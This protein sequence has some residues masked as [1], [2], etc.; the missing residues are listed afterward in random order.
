MARVEAAAKLV[1]Y[2]NIPAIG[3]RRGT[4]VVGKNGVPK[5]GM[6]GING[7]EM[8]ATNLKFQIRTYVN[9]QACYITVGTDYKEAKAILERVRNTRKRETLDAKLGITIPKSEVELAA[10]KAAEEAENEASRKTLAQFGVEYL[11]K[12]EAL[13]RHSTALYRCIPGFIEY[14]GKKFPEDLTERDVVSW[15]NSLKTKGYA[16][17]TCQTRYSTLRGF[18]SSIGINLNVL[19]DKAEHRKMNRKPDV[20]T[21]PYDAEQLE[22]LFLACDPYQLVAFTVLLMT[23]FRDKEAAHLTWKEIKWK[24]NKIVLEGEKHI[25]HPKYK[26]MVIPF[27]TKNGKG[28]EV[29]LFPS[30]KKVLEDWRE[31]NPDTTFVIGTKGDLPPTHLLRTLKRL[32]GNNGLNCGQCESC[33]SH[34]VCEEFYL[35]RFRHTFAATTLEKYNIHQVSRWMGHSSIAVTAIYLSGTAKDA[36]IDP[37]A[38]ELA[39]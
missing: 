24:V 12:K 1:Q 19:I 35:H 26:G 14:T 30:L 25:H 29:P 21:E 20:N 23:G 27:K 32:A 9:R 6:I 10:E 39:A 11:A 15:Y 8:T 18:L 37:F 17:R 28:R 3:W 36:T 5:P 16:Q 34:D 33:A 22:T 38:L 7:Q 13:S 4:I 31:R 2:G